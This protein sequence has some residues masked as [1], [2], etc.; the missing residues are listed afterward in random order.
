MRPAQRFGDVVAHPIPKERLLAG[1][2][3][4]KKAAILGDN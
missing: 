4:E 1:L 2:R 3:I